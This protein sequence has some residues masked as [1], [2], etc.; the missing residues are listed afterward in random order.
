MQQGTSRHLAH[1]I[2]SLP[3]GCLPPLKAGSLSVS[4]ARSPSDM[5]AAQA[6][7]YEVFGREMGGALTPE[8]HRAQRDFDALDGY[9]DHLL[10]R[11]EHAHNTVVGTYRLLRRSVLPADV[12]FYTESEFNIGPIRSQAGEILELSRSCVAKP[13]RGRAVIQLLWRGIA[14]YMEHYDVALMFGCASFHGTDPTRFA[15]A[16][17]YLHHYHCAG[18]GY[19]PSAL[20]E[21]YVEMDTMPKT[22]IDVKS[23]FAALPALLKGYLRVGCEVG[24]GA[25]VDPVFKTTDVC[26]VMQTRRVKKRYARKFIPILSDR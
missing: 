2:P 7:R 4:L 13:Y 18:G 5:H 11:D 21:R 25:I 9:C 1:T 26:I 6:L 22:S 15:R 16:L 10:V 19:C 23:A 3:A 24:R 17:S 12:P 8:I 20:P 14:A